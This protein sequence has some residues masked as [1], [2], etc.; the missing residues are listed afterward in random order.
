MLHFIYWEG[1]CPKGWGWEGQLDN[2]VAFQI[3]LRQAAS[4]IRPA[5]LLACLVPSFT[6]CLSAQWG[7]KAASVILLPSALSSEQP[8]WLA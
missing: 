5:L 6:P 8:G 3:L 1:I 4:W 2:P 7:P